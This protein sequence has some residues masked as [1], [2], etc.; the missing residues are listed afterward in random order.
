MHT[1][2]YKCLVGLYVS[3]TLAMSH[4]HYHLISV[5]R[6]EEDR[7]TDRWFWAY[8]CT[9]E[10]AE[11]A[12]ILHWAIN[13]LREFL[14]LSQRSVMVIWRTKRIFWDCQFKVSLNLHSSAGK[15]F[16]FLSLWHLNIIEHFKASADTCAERKQN[17]LAYDEKKVK[18]AFFIILF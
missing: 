8:S 7:P 2:I 3:H 10:Q 1:E 14:L 5:W 4:L 18:K 9:R 12:D 17:C 13:S 6:L 11:E 16:R 15:C